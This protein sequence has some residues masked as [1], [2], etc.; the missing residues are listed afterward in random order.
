V[1]A[2]V[3]QSHPYY[4]Q[5]RDLAQRGVISGFADGT[6]RPQDPVTRQQ[7]AKMIVLTLGYP[8]TRSDTCLFT[9]VDKGLDPRDPFYPYNHVAVCAAHLITQGVTATAFAPTR[10]VTRAQL[11]TMVAR[12]ANL[13]DPP[14]AYVPPFG[15]F[16]ATHYPWARKAA[17]AGLL[18]GL[19][20]MGPGY[21]FFTSA[22]RG[23]VCVLLYNLLQR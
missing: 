18:N 8:V 15:N 22:T 21:A 5:I 10:N 12:A 4:V 11:I 16:S 19:Q 3:A 23:E 17:Y 13:P 7:F 14:A 6:F 2:D 9:D 1:F 20:G